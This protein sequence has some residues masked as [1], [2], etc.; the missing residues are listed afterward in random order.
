VSILQWQSTVFAG[1]LQEPAPMGWHEELNIL[2]STPTN[3][4]FVCFIML[5]WEQEHTPLSAIVLG[6]KSLSNYWQGL[7]GAAPFIG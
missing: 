2:F 3:F 5:F 7:E 6:R 1:Q 4:F